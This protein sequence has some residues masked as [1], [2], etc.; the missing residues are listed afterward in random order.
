MSKLLWGEIGSREELHENLDHI[1]TKINNGIELLHS[2]A[3]LYHAVASL[4]PIRYISHLYLFAS[5]ELQI[6]FGCVFNKNMDMLKCPHTLQLD[7]ILE[8]S[9]TTLV[10]KPFHESSLHK[11]RNGFPTIVRHISHLVIRSYWC[12]A[13]YND[14]R[15]IRSQPVRPVIDEDLVVR[16]LFKWS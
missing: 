7:P 13:P 8:P 16:R 3:V 15:N 4:L 6:V 12:L 11:I 5:P 9:H 1:R 10:T 14:V 2:A